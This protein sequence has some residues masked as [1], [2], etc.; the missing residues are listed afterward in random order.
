MSTVTSFSFLLWSGD[1]TNVGVVG[2]EVWRVE[3]M[4]SPVEVAPAVTGLLHD[5]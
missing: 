2:G 4:A 5:A 1:E 3:N